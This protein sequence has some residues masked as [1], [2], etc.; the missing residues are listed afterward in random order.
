VTELLKRA[1]RIGRLDQRLG[2]V[3]LPLH[4]ALI[5]MARLYR[6]DRDEALAVLEEIDAQVRRGAETIN[7]RLMDLL[8]AERLESGS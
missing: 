6:L 2:A 3:A 1:A 8:P 7:L 5:A 4:D